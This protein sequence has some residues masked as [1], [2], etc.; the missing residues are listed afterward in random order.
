MA[1]HEKGLVALNL[2][3]VLFPSPD[4]M[5]T[6]TIPYSRSFT[7]N[8]TRADL[9]KNQDKHSSLVHAILRVILL[10]LPP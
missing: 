10:Q 2:A 5:Q 9:W 1:M 8:S 6:L 7:I 3:A 4:G